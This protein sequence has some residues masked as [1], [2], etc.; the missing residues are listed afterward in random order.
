MKTTITVLNLLIV[1]CFSACTSGLSDNLQPT[2]IAQPTVQQTVQQTA[3]PTT[4]PPTETPE[5]T[6][7]PQP[8]ATHT[9][10][11]TATAVPLTILEPVPETS[12]TTGAVLTV[13][14]IDE[15][16]V[17]DTVHISAAIGEWVLTE[18]E[19]A[20][21]RDG[22]WE[23]T[24]SLPPQISG[25]AV[26]T[27]QTMTAQNSQMLPIY[28]SPETD[29]NSRYILLNRPYLGETAVAGY[30][31]FFNGEINRPVNDTLVIGLLHDG[32]SHFATS[33]TFELG[34]GQWQGML[35]IPAD[36]TGP[37]CAIARSGDP[38]ELD[39]WT[40]SL[41]PLTILAKEDEQAASITLGN[42]GELAFSASEPLLLFGTAVH[43]P[44]NKIDLLLT[45]DDGTFKLLAKETVDVN[46]F[47]YWEIEV[48]LSESYTGHALLTAAM[49]N[50]ADYRELRVP[51]FFTR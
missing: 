28:I 13:R 14:G 1:L 6:L 51:L 27:V 34:S 38:E 5:S 40:A 3:Q 45:S 33:R 39:E 18:A 25:P 37:V 43:A 44:N 26:L 15:T 7:T 23:I 24:L 30:G 49:G 42:A 50:D 31:V 16:A 47:G 29:A 36:I 20:V 8:T 11:P 35:V 41:I 2:Q 17:G 10:T 48:V 21:S 32:C 19:T 12:L 46:T 9:A 4:L 22:S